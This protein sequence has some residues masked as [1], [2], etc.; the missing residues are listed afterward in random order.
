M[1]G[2]PR[3]QL[4]EHLLY[5]KL[6]MPQHTAAQ[7]ECINSIAAQYGFFWNTV[8]NHA[9]NAA[10]RAKRKDPNV[11]MPGDVVYVPDKQPKKESAATDQV[12]KYRL[13]GIPVPL[14]LRLLENGQPRT[15]VPYR[16]TVG[17]VTREGTIGG[18]GLISVMV[19]PDVPAGKLLLYPN[20]EKLREEYQ[21]L[22]R[23][24]DPVTELSGV[25]G[26][27]ENLGFYRGPVD[28]NP[29]PETESAVKT[30]QSSR[31]L[32]ESGQADTATQAALLAAHGA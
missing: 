18:D 12:H 26:R 16:L 30:F 15:G 13:K 22:V 5:C 24:L 6:Q 23:R 7:D 1:P 14:K 8:W 17:P 4:D 11:L 27:L 31:G 20:D 3:R 21:V 32:P 10:L 2:P 28:G 29:S 25:Q 9:N 19:M